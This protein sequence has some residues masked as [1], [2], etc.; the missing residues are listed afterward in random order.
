MMEWSV[1]FLCI[2]SK[3]MPMVWSG[4]A[5]PILY[6]RRRRRR[7]NKWTCCLTTRFLLHILLVLL[8]FLLRMLLLAFNLNMSQLVAH[9]VF[10]SAFWLDQASSFPTEFCLA[11]ISTFLLLW[12][13]RYF[14]TDLMTFVNFLFNLKSSKCHLY[15]VFIHFGAYLLSHTFLHQASWMLHFSP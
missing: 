10:H 6:G 2:Q 8:W 7:S 3:E 14:V 12:T 4:I 1:Y 5:G 15:A 11:R 9:F 13:V